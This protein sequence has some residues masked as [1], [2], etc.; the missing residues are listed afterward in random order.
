MSQYA[1]AHKNHVGKKSEAVI[2]AP[3]YQ[4]LNYRA[5]FPGN[6]NLPVIKHAP[7]AKVTTHKNQQ[8]SLHWLIDRQIG[9]L[10]F[11]YTSYDDVNGCPLASFV[12]SK[13]DK[14][15]QADPALAKNR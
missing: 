13:I 1:A 3:G 8:T 14:R 11:T 6:Y 9:I 4:A 12:L 7:D 2:L 10:S 5:P 15:I